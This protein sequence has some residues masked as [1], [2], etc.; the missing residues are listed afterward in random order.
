MALDTL[1][2]SYVD[3]LFAIVDTI[4]ILKSWKR[5]FNLSEETFRP[6]WFDLSAIIKKIILFIPEALQSS[7]GLSTAPD[8]FKWPVIYRSGMS[9][10]SGD[11]DGC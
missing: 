6:S 4:L 5:F 8:K 3:I 11:G 9:S 1:I 7:L 2:E 10:W